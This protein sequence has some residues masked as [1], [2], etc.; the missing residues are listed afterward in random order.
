MPRGPPSKF[1]A[2][3][4]EFIVGC[5]ERGLLYATAAKRCGV[6]RRTIHRWRTAGK[7]GVK[8]FRQ[9]YLDLRQA[10]AAATIRDLEII[11]QCAEAGD[12]RAAAWRLAFRDPKRYG[13]PRINVSLN[14]PS[15]RDIDF[16]H[17]PR[18]S[19]LSSMS[20]RFNLAPTKSDRMLERDRLGEQPLKARGLLHQRLIAVVNRWAG[21]TMPPVSA[22]ASRIRRC[23]RR[24][25][26]TESCLRVREQT[27]KSA[28]TP[29]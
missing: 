27:S 21:F 29:G 24:Q 28:W 13:R 9:F 7:R 16:C 1:D 6:S 23:S 25:C 5:I 19:K 15:A 8:R 3:I 26:P 2:E 17:R 18:G 10:T 4:A 22:V 14:R 12:W 11:R 20:N